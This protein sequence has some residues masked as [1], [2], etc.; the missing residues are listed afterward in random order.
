MQKNDP[1]YGHTGGLGGL[2][3]M[4][5]GFGGIAVALLDLVFVS[6]DKIS[7]KLGK[8]VGFATSCLKSRRWRK[9]VRSL[10]VAV[11]GFDREH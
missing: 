8:S 4:L 2:G 5:A 11:G 3:G 9:S 7:G 10:F 1:Q 6:G